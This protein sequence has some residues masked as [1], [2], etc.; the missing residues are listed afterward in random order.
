MNPQSPHA[1]HPAVQAGGGVLG[2]AAFPPKFPRQVIELG[3][4]SVREA[5]LPP[6]QLKQE[7]EVG[8][9][10]SHKFSS[11]MLLR[12]GWGPALASLCSPLGCLVAQIPLRELGMIPWLSL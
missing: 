2:G 5:G 9:E 7:P 12:M 1:T 8:N 11:G 4:D 10:W 3:E 6:C